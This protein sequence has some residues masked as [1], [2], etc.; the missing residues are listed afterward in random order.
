MKLFHYLPATYA[1]DDLR[2]RRLKIARLDEL[3]DPF[4]LVAA[5]QSNRE[6]RAIWRGWR[7]AQAERWGILCFSKTWRN[8]VLWSHYA[9]RH[10]GICLGFEVAEDVLM[11]VRYMKNRLRIDIEALHEQGKLRPDLMHKLLRTKYSDWSYEREVRVFSSI[12]AKDEDTGLYFYGFGEKLRLVEVIAGPLC[13]V[14]ESEIR[15]SVQDEDGGARVF[16][17]RL[18]FQS[19]EIV[20]DQRGFLRE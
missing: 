5:D 6:Q 14:P 8:P 18:G 1:L 17:A 10:R 2:R 11:P 16:K 9:D 19:F 12:E 4:E 3:N 13:P 15:A 7:K 20:E